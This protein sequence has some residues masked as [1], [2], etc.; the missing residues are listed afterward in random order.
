[1]IHLNVDGCKQTL[2]VHFFWHSVSWLK[3]CYFQST[4]VFCSVFYNHVSAPIGQPEAPA[5]GL[6]AERRQTNFKLL[7]KTGESERTEQSADVHSD[8][9]SVGQLQ[10]QRKVKCQPPS[11][12][13]PDGMISVIR[14]E[15][16]AWRRAAEKTRM[17]TQLDSTG[18]YCWDAEILGE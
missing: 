1:M 8:V 11:C 6:T 17:V 4:V 15:A 7:N 18:K 12:F 5:S 2:S 10:S 16:R 13:S 14:S 9:H 3:V